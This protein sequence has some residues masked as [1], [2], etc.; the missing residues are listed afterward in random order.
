MSTNGNA[1]AGEKK[2]NFT[3]IKKD[4]VPQS[5]KG[6]HHDIV[7]E[8]LA[9]LDKLRSGSAL[10]IPLSAMGDAKAVNVRAALTRAAEQAGVHIGTRTDDEYFYVWVE[11]Q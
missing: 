9:D 11:K 6:K 1:G 7:S 10:R 2:L 4:D 8:I 3:S 5:R